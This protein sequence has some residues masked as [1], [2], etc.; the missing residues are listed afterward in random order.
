VFPVKCQ[1]MAIKESSDELNPAVVIA[2]PVEQLPRVARSAKDYLALAIGTCGVGYLPIAPGT[3]GSVV[4]VGIYLLLQS[5]FVRFI[6][7]LPP[8][9]FLRFLPLPIF[10]AAELV[11]I[12]VV[13][14]VGIWAAS[15]MEKLLAR[16]D[17]GKVV[18]DEVAGQLIALLPIMPRLDPGWTS[19]LTAFLL[20]RL[21]DIVKPYPAR[22][23][24]GLESG[25]GIMA[26]DIV[27]GAYAA[28]G[29]SI[30]IALGLLV[31]T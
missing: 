25:L 16:K 21:F 22:R 9:S 23:L 20:F 28:V 24:E 14:L 2:A 26:D 29:T 5:V 13:T 17:P 7:L 18:I 6:Q 1:R 30:I 11:L 15:R 3:W 8:D 4:G 19:I 12:T 31:L 10:I 27:A